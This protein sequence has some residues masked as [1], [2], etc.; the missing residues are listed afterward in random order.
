M[1]K[2]KMIGTKIAALSPCVAK[3][4]EFEATGLVDYNV[5]FKSLDEYIRKNYV[6]LPAE[7][8]EFDNFG[9]GLGSIYAMP[10]GLKECVEHYTGKALRIDK[11]EG[12][13][14]VYHALNEYAKQ[15][16]EN[17]PAV[18]D[19]LNCPE[20]C[21]AGTG[22]VHNMDAL[23]IN[24][25]M[26][27][28]RQAAIKENNS[29]Y[30]KE[31]F[32]KFDDTLRLEDFIREY[33]F[34]SMPPII[35]SEEEIEKAFVALGKHDEAAKNYNCGACGSDTCHEMA[36]KIAK[37][38]NIPENCTQKVH[39]DVDVMIRKISDEMD[40]VAKA[41][42]LYNKMVTDIERI[43]E[44]VN[45][46]SLNASVEAAKAGQHGVT[47]EVVAKTIRKLAQSSAD[48]AEKTKE[49]SERANNAMGAVNKTIL[50]IKEKIQ[51][52]HKIN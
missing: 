15:P 32:K 8:K 27:V 42:S 3:T 41:I 25:K 2:Y 5:T 44:K 30:T 31:L 22:C 52:T 6:S 4:H 23:E 34:S 45:I 17:L 28:L 40:G 26:D 9:A 46:I 35:V 49:A 20:G 38:V 51:S 10:G 16:L 24:T 21:N 39:E 33:S 14:V 36:R 43:S 48:S 47:F 50:K 1:K 7:S 13:K 19:V 37:G 29:Q 12:Q 18:F 11:S